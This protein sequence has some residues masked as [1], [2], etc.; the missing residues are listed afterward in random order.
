MTSPSAHCNLRTFARGYV[1]WLN[2]RMYGP[3]PGHTPSGPGNRTASVFW[4]LLVI[5]A[6]V[7]V[8]A[9][10]FPLI[11]PALVAGM[12]AAGMTAVMNVSIALS[13]ISSLAFVVGIPVLWAR[14]FYR[15][16]KHCCLRGRELAAAIRV[17]ALTAPSR[18]DRPLW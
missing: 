14:R 5:P 2:E 8:V 15:F 13:V 10:L 7:A 6:G 17:P 16:T 12:S 11:A 9:L 3:A 1:D 4:L 18:P